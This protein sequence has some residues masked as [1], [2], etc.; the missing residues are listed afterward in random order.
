ME[1]E[2]SRK[3]K[4]GKEESA[5]SCLLVDLL[6]ERQAHLDNEALIDVLLGDRIGGVESSLE[7]VRKLVEL[8]ELPF[9][10][11]SVG[12]TAD[13]R[14]I[15]VVFLL[16]ERNKGERYIESVGSFNGHRKEGGMR[17][18]EGKRRRE[19]DEPR[20]TGRTST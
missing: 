2:G 20:S 7:E 1:K 9:R 16:S 17:W 13:G 4:E 8:S 18:V 12:S 11:G 3:V 6:R 10:E 14:R 15:L 19:K 5:S